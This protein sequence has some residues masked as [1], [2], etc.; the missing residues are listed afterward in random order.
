MYLIDTNVFLEF[1]LDQENAET[2]S[3]LFDK[4]INGSDPIFI[5]GFTLHSMPQRK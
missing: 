4:L 5:T 2:A 1:L 3:Q